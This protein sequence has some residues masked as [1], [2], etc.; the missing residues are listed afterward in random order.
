LYQR[1]APSTQ[2]NTTSTFVPNTQAQSKQPFK[3]LAALATRFNTTNTNQHAN[4]I[5]TEN[6]VNKLK[7]TISQTKI[8]N[9]NGNSNSANI[10]KDTNAISNGNKQ[11]S[12]NFIAKNN[13]SSSQ[14][15]SASKAIIKSHQK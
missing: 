13:S 9:N 6:L 14:N 11:A 4:A 2:P 15:Y 8:V 3:G 5:E 7:T 10:V 12:S 1:T